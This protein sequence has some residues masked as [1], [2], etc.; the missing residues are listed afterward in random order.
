MDLLLLFTAPSPPLLSPISRFPLRRTFPAKIGY[1]GSTLAAA[2]AVTAR[3]RMVV[4]AKYRPKEEEHLPEVEKDEN[5][6]A[7]EERLTPEELEKIA[8]AMMDGEDEGR[9]P[10]DYDRRA[11]IFHESSLVFRE[12]NRDY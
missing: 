1:K 11:R 2:P 10:L 8:A 6:E 3:R 7:E 4:M 12:V 5:L 9:T